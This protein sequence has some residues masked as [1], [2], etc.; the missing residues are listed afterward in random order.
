MHVNS[1]IQ[2]FLYYYAS[3]YT[4]EQHFSLC[5]TRYGR[6]LVPTI[7]DVHQPARRM[8]SKT[9]S[10]A[11]E[12]LIVPLIA[13]I[14]SVIS[15]RVLWNTLG[16][17]EGMA[18]NLIAVKR[19]QVGLLLREHSNMWIIW[20]CVTSI[21]VKRSQP[22]RERPVTENEGGRTKRRRRRIRH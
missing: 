10:Q 2:T 14:C 11:L 3:I 1:S 15:F 9:I 5:I 13:S 7:I 16:R 6:S 4:S 22:R 12:K 21:Q 18:E 8:G 17:D 19:Q 20:S